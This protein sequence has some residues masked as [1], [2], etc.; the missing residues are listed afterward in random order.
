MEKYGITENAAVEK[1]LTEVDTKISKDTFRGRV[2]RG[3]KVWLEGNP[4]I[5]NG[6]RL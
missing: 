5:F 2:K 6:V 4:P 3:K 1:H